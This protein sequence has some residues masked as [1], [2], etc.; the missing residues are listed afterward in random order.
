[1]TAGIRPR[2]DAL[3][4]RAGLAVLLAGLVLGA[5]PRS[6]ARAELPAEVGSAPSSTTLPVPPSKHWVWINDPDF[7]HMVDGRAHLIDGDTGRYLGALSTG[8]SYSHVVLPRDGKLIYSAETYF[9]R[10]TRGARTDV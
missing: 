1:M 6:A 10:G 3:R 7:D 9:A 2:T 8:Y 4:A 5:V